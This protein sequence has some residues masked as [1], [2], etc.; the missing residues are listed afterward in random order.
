MGAT[1]GGTGGAGLGEG[2]GD[3]LGPSS[4]GGMR[5]RALGSGLSGAVGEA[6]CDESSGEV[7]AGAFAKLLGGLLC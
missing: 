3:A 1:L 6:L 2:N 7:L 4:G 5:W